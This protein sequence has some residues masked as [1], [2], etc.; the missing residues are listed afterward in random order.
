QQV[1]LTNTQVQKLAKKFFN[2][3][4]T[5]DNFRKYL[6]KRSIG[7]MIQKPKHVFLIIGESLDSWSLQKQ[8]DHFNL[9]TNLH[10]IINSNHSLF[11]RNFLPFANGT[12]DAIDTIVAGV[13]DTDLHINYQPNSKTAYPT[14]MAL[15]F[16]ALGFKTQ[17]F[18]GGYL[19]WQ[20]VGDF[21]RSQGFEEV[22]GAAHIA[23]WEQTNEWGVDDRALFNFVLDKIKEADTPTFNIIMTVSNHPPFSIN[24]QKEG[25]HM[26]VNSEKIAEKIK[27]LGHIWYADKTMGEF[28]DKMLLIDKNTLFAITGD[29]FSRRHVEI[30]PNQYDL[31]AV[32]FI[33]YSNN[34]KNNSKELTAS[35][36]HIDIAA[37]LINLIAPKNFIY[38]SFGDN[39]LA[40][41][42]LDC[43]LGKGKIITPKLVM[44]VD[45]VDNSTNNSVYLEKYDQLVCLT[46]H[47]IIRGT[48]LYDQAKKE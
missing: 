42:T 26:A 17:F 8:Y 21:I 16:K 22:Y 36:S 1:N 38:Y 2:K 37:T 25:F 20:K 7:P 32:P 3:N 48:D 33:I 23:S 46:R 47:F 39:L 19:S 6:E 29:H 31:S 15:Q 44:C 5:Y 35:G 28:V 14:A 10:R 12:M 4:Y 34:I 27:E 45:N 18:Y 40:K 30:S 43:G 11:F 24:L 41:R 9:H 13:P